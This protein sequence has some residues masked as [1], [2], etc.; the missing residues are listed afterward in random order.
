MSEPKIF[1]TPIGGP[2]FWIDP[3][4]MTVRGTYAGRESN[5]VVIENERWSSSCAASP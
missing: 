1:T 5:L 2:I 4:Q 3:R